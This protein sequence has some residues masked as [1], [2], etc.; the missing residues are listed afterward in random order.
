VVRIN[1]AI[2]EQVASRSPGFISASVHRRA[3]GSVV[4]NHLQW[5]SAD[6]L[7]GMQRSSEFQAIARHRTSARWC[8][9]PR[10]GE[11]GSPVMALERA[12][13]FVLSS[14]PRIEKRYQ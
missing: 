7:A 9:S 13:T 10:E 5:R 12:L 4:V 8:T 14:G 11:L 3:D 1:V 6:H 2:V